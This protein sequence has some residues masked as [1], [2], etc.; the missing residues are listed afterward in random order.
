[1]ELGLAGK[2]VVDTRGSK[3]IGR[4][5]LSRLPKKGRTFLSAP[6]VKQISLLLKRN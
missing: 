6:V 4:Q 3:G 5:L 1:M 2:R